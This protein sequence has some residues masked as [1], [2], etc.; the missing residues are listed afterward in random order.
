MARFVPV[1]LATPSTR[2]QTGQAGRIEIR[3]RG[4]LTV[5]VDGV[6]D[7]VVLKLVLGVVGELGG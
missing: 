1:E 3:G 5:S 7:R 6:V 4:G 2:Q